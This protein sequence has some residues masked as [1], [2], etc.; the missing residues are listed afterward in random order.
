MRK[1]TV[2]YAEDLSSKNRACDTRHPHNRMAVGWKANAIANSEG[3]K[4]L[5]YIVD[6][7]IERNAQG[8]VLELSSEISQI[9]STGGNSAY[10]R[11][12]PL[13]CTLDYCSPMKSGRGLTETLQNP[14]QWPRKWLLILG[15]K[16]PRY[17]LSQPTNATWPA[18]LAADGSDGS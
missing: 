9:R 4:V 13:G 12:R 17:Q 14:I 5:L 6:Q 15:W 10:F 7:I 16:S 18:P 3:I 11:V 8:H 2:E 1:L